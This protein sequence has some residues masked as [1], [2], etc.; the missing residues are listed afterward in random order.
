MQEIFSP[1][2]L[3]INPELIV[4]SIRTDGFFAMER[5]LTPE[6]LKAIEDDVRKCSSGVNRNGISGVYVNNQYYLNQMLAISKYFYSYATSNKLLD[7][8][9]ALV[10]SSFRLKA[11]RY[12][13]TYA[14]S[15]Q[16]WHTDNKIDR[17][18][19]HIPGLIAIAYVSDVERGEFQYVR[20]SQAWS[21][22]RSYNEYTDEFISENL[23]EDVISFKMPAGSIII[24]D[25]YGI[26]RANP[27][28][29]SFI[30]KSLFL[31]VDAELNNAEPL[32]I[33]PG[34]FDNLDDRL[35]AYLG[36][37]RP[38]EY[39]I[40]PATSYKDLPVLSPVGR[41]LFLWLPFRLVRGVYDWLPFSI[42]VLVRKIFKST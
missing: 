38:G 42:K 24:Y 21:G 16:V 34:F 11:I 4:R 3:E 7:I 36:F 20:G 27:A 32:L 6:F 5:A 33:N 39:P 41:T 2:F 29:G 31:Q 22:E 28:P 12:Y 19:I 1:A 9:E 37:G 10:G 17:S 35:K 14:G 18:H 13:E 30:R 15:K 25:T 26:H 40:F 8:C 23:S